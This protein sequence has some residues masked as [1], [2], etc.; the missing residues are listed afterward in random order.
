MKDEEILRSLRVTR[1]F[2][3]NPTRRVIAANTVSGF[4]EHEGYDDKAYRSN[5]REIQTPAYLN[6]PRV[7]EFRSGHVAP[8]GNRD[9]RGADASQRGDER[10]PGTTLYDTQVEKPAPAYLK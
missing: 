9:R 5:H 7:S 10:R 3:S 1:R 8:I 2:F 4:H 6:K